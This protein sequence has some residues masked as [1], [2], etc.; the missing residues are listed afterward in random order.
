MIFNRKMR[1]R[2]VKALKDAGMNVFRIRANDKRPVAEGWQD[3]ALIADVK[4]WSNGRDYN[5][6]VATGKGL[7]VI[8]PDM[9]HGIDGEANWKALC[10]EHDIEESD[11]QIATPN[12]GRH[13]YYWHDLGLK[14]ANSASKIA[15]GVDVR[16]TGGYVVGPGSEIPEGEYTVINK[17][18]KIAQAPQALIDLCSQKVTRAGD[19]AVPAG[20][21]DV[22]ENVERAKEYLGGNAPLAVEGEGGDQTTFAVAARVRDMGISE[23]MCGEL[24]ADEWNSRCSPPWSGDEL[25]VKVNNAYKYSSGKI[26]GDTAEAQFSDEPDS[27]PLGPKAPRKGMTAVERMNERHALVAVGSSHVIIEEYLDEDGRQQTAQYSERTFHAM[28]VKDSFLDENGKRVYLSHVWAKSPDRRTY[29]GFT[30][31]PRRVGPVHGKYNHWRGFMFAPLEIEAEEAKGK[32]DLYLKHIRDVVC[33][34]DMKAYRWIIN[35]FAHMVQYPWKKPE[36]AIVITGAKGAGKSLIFDV[37]GALVRDNYVVTAEKRM[38]LGN[39]NSHM[40]QAILFQFEEAFWA[41]DK[42]AEGKFKLMVT[43]KHNMIERKGYEPYMVGNFARIGVTSNEKWVVPASVDE[44]RWAV[45]ACLATMAGNKAYFNAI[46]TQLQAGGGDGYRALMTVLMGVKVDQTM[47]HV[48]PTT[49]ALGDQKVETLDTVAKWLMGSL[50]VG[51]IEGMG[52]GFE[53]ELD[54]DEAWPQDVVCRD[55]YEAYKAF[56]K[57]QGFRY[58]GTQSA[59]GRELRRILGGEGDGDYD[60]EY[61]FKRTKKRVGGH[62]EWVYRFNGLAESRKKFEK[63]LGHERIW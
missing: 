50:E 35:Y 61:D 54:G 62:P 27:E 36:T 23:E 10:D 14:I 2:F 40:E 19:Y 63:W 26:G 28:A 5:V 51:S 17:G 3:E 53:D 20:D 25:G 46:Y 31:D 11:F 38:L 33:G 55:A 45:F 52:T 49:D 60:Q 56:V 57:D 6:G 48:P 29:R 43:G 18:A 16:G 15:K 13:I 58:P 22:M 59:F 21:L 8:D 24:M 7:L 34:G 1:R 37:M 44:R 39:F 4:Q 47:V 42:A 9:K 30:F 12:G 32:C 41:G